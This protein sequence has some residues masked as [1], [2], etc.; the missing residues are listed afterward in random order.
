MDA[1]KNMALSKRLNSIWNSPDFS[2]FFKKYS[3][4]PPISI[5]K[6]KT[7]FF[8]GDEPGKLY[9]IKKGF[10]KV[11]RMS[12]E[13]RSTIIYLYGPGSMLAIRALTTRE[14]RLKHTAEAITDV[15]VITFPEK[16]YFE[17]LSE[18]P[19]YL[20]DLLQI[21]I[22]RLNYTER[23]LEGFILT[24]TTARVANFLYDI[25]IRF[26]ERKNG[27]VVLPLPLTHQ[28]I[29]DFVGAFRETVTVAISRLKK[30]GILKDER[31]KIT[32]LDLKK[33]K[34]QALI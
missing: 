10:A 25:S 32:I 16:D 3:K 27:K 21:F 8:E 1:T 11:Y 28:T 34:Q 24:D 5:K 17:V 2:S 33:L 19:E 15:E 30:E 13:G 23:K 26:G 9:F 14:K 7:I 12:P 22:E 18:N 20:V 4:R 31:G 6:G 29:S